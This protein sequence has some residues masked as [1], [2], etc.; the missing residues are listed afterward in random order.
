MPRRAK[1]LGDRSV[2]EDDRYLFLQTIMAA[3]ERLY[4]SYP[5]SDL[6]SGED[7]GPSVLLAEFIEHV[8][9]GY[10]ADPEEASKVLLTRQ[11]MH[12]FSP[13]LFRQDAEN[14]P[15]TVHLSRRMAGGGGQRPPFG[16]GDGLCRQY[17]A[18]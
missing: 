8:C 6:A 12:P 17:L 13:R 11:P 15:Q 16:I 9:H 7:R 2:R 4:L 18:G 14:E 5:G 10:F 1:R 3:H